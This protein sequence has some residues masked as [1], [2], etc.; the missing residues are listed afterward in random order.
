MESLKNDGFKIAIDDFGS[1][2]SNLKRL[3]SID[4]DFIKIDRDLINSISQDSKRQLI[5]ETI[6]GLS[7]KLN[8]LCI[9]EGVED[10][11]D[12]T[13]CYKAGINLF[14]G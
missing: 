4:P 3:V 10:I 12:V 14:Q 13:F 7:Y 9:A 5:V 2:Y 11:N 6:C 8:I 1:A